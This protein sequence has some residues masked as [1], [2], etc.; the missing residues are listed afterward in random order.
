M[1]RRP[2]AHNT[3]LSQ[4][5]DTP[6][7]FANPSIIDLGAIENWMSVETRFLHVCLFRVPVPQP[8]CGTGA[9]VLRTFKNL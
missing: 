2:S 6:S 4:Q 9:E 5:P 8:K 1:V 3:G 7:P